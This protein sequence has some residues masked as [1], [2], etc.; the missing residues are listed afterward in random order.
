M[1]QTIRSDSA[2]DL[3]VRH[4]SAPLRSL[5]YLWMPKTR[6][7]ELHVKI[8]RGKQT[9]RLLYCTASKLMLQSPY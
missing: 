6:L 3:E 7:V 5:Q 4:F 9:L 2:Y 8:L 1:Y